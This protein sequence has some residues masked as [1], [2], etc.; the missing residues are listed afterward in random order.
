MQALQLDSRRKKKCFLSAVL[1]H[2]ASFLH[3]S[4]QRALPTK[5][6][7]RQISS[8]DLES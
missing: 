6:R 4:E 3:S 5:E 8:F 2:Q 1:R 7:R